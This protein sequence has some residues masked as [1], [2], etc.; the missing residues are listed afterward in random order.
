MSEPR[1][2]QRPEAID[3]LILDEAADWLMQLCAGATDEER[4]ACERW[5]K[6]SPEHA[7]AWARAQLL[8]NKL[9]GL[10]SSLAMPALNREP[11]AGRRAAITKLAAILALAPASWGIWK[12]IAAQDWMA[13][14]R[15][16]VGEQ[17]VMHLA[18]SSEVTLN[19]ATTFN[20]HFNSAQRNINLRSGEILVQTAREATAIYRPFSVSTTQGRMEA[21]G[22]RFSVRVNEETTHLAVLEGAVRITPNQN[23]L[24]QV[25]HAGQ[26]VTFTKNSIGEIAEADNVVIAWAEGMLVA[27]R[28]RLADFAAELSRYRSGIVRV[29][30]AVAQVRVSGAFP[31]RDTDK[32]LAMLVST[33]PVDA[34][35]R[36][37]G[38]WITLVAR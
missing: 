17:R 16:A 4:R 38:H 12:V 33:Y 14:C 34:Q 32:A 28:M 19:T 29:D 7:R 24:Q 20:V 3:P 9:G 13:D 25:L 35:T 15:T 37:R 6:R 11:A 23:A 36:L 21:L 5:S 27:D 10:P 1:V 18:D 22:T 8:L 26:Q 31:L 30:P 2:M